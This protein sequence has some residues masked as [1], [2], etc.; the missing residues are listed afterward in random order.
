MIQSLEILKNIYKCYI[1]S[2]FF[3]DKEVNLWYDISR[4]NKKDCDNMNNKKLSKLY[5]GGGVL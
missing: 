5:I 1:Y 2:A 3:V 4:K